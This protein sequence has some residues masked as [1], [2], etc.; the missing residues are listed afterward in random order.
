MHINESQRINKKNK[1][2][3]FWTKKDTVLDRINNMPINLVKIALN[4]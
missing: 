3:E 2:F 1:F 4:S